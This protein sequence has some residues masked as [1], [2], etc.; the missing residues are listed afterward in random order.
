ME[1][2]EITFRLD[3]IEE[4]LRELLEAFAKPQARWLS[5]RG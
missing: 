1:N 5:V 2:D 4:M 3:R